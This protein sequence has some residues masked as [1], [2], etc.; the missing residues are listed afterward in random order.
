LFQRIFIIFVP[1]FKK[2]RDCIQQ[3]ILLEP[4]L[5][6][7][8]SPVTQGMVRLEKQ[9]RIVKNL[10]RKEHDLHAHVEELF[11]E[12][13]GL[14]EKVSDFPEASI[15]VRDDLKPIFSQAG[16]PGMQST[17]PLR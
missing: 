1:H 14:Y 11:A 3:L 6:E 13:L 4:R 5:R 2:I 16:S 12:I 10:E 15:E 7:K 17:K 9:E 8:A